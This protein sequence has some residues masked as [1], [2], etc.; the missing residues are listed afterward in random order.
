MQTATLRKTFEVES[1]TE[2]DFWVAA[3]LLMQEHR[4]GEN[5]NVVTRIAA[6]AYSM[7]FSAMD[8]VKALTYELA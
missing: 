2:K 4:D 5:V 7:V 6:E 3:L 8:K 1:Y